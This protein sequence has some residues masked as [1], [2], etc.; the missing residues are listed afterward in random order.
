MLDASND[1]S[2]WSHHGYTIVYI[3]SVVGPPMS[4]SVKTMGQNCYFIFLSLEKIIL[5]VSLHSI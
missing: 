3:Q 2:M 4:T 5:E 1:V